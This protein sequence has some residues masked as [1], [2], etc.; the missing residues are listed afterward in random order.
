[1]PLSDTDIH[2]FEVVVEQTLL[3]APMG[4]FGTPDEIAAAICFLASHD[5]SYFVGQTLYVAGDGIG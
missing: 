3:D 1:V 4:R 2:G 5:A